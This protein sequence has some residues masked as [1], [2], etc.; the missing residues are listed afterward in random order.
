MLGF[1]KFYNKTIKVNN[2]QENL[3]SD[4]LPAHPHKTLSYIISYM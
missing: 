3:N 2:L 4:I 1:S